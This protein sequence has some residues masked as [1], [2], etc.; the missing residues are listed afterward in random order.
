[1]AKRYNN[2]N[3]EQSKEIVSAQWLPGIWKDAEVVGFRGGRVAVRFLCDN[4][5]EEFAQNKVRNLR[6]NDVQAEEVMWDN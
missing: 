2:F 3:K 6:L 5:I 1:M 4:Y